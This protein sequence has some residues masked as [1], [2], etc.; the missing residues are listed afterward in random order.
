VKPT[1]SYVSDTFLPKCTGLSE[2]RVELIDYDFD[3][4]G[5][6]KTYRAPDER[7]ERRKKRRQSVLA[8][9]KASTLTKG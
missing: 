5:G 4:S 6:R 3:D 7:D 9:G 1:C 2:V 8:V